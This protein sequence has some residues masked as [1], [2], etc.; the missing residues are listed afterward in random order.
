MR[1]HGDCLK[2]EAVSD[3]ANIRITHVGK[4]SD[5]RYRGVLPPQRPVAGLSEDDLDE[6][7]E[8]VAEKVAQIIL[9][10]GILPLDLPSDQSS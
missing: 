6:I 3:P 7:A 1:T 4:D 8:R 2:G 5:I 10:R 9:K